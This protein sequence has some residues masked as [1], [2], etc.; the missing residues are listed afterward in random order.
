L[1]EV[2]EAIYT[3]VLIFKYFGA[4]D[5]YSVNPSFLVGDTSCPTILVTRMLVL[6][7]D[8]FVLFGIDIA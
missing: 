4:A 7:V 5:D 2:I 6:S 8:G 1:P 3:N